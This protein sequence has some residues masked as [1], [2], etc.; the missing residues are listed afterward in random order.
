MKAGVDVDGSVSINMKKSIWQLPRQTCGSKSISFG[1]L[2]HAREELSQTTAEEGHA[3]D[4]IGLFDAPCLNVVQG[5]DQ[6]CRGEREETAEQGPSV[7]RK[8]TKNF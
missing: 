2:P 8:R 1:E 3:Y 4:D 6:G 7:N 5:E